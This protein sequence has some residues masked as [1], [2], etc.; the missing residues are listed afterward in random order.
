MVDS[1]QRLPIV[2]MPLAVGTPPDNKNIVGRE[3]TVAE[4]CDLLITGTSVALTGDRRYGK[5]SVKNLIV[6]ELPTRGARIVAISAQRQSLTDV[7]SALITQI[8]GSLDGGALGDFDKWSVQVKLGPATLTR[9]SAAARERAEATLEGAI[10]TVASLTRDRLV[11]AIDEV[12]EL[13]IANREDGA[14]LVRMLRRIRQEHPTRVSMLLLGSM[15][16]HH[17]DRAAPGAFNDVTSIAVGPISERDGVYLARCLM[18]GAAV[19]C[20]DGEVPVAQATY[21]AA[22]GIPYYVH[23]LVRMASRRDGRR[24]HSHDVASEVAAA[25]SDEQDPW[26]MR[27]YTDRVPGYYG[28]QADLAYAALDAYAVSPA[29]MDVDALVADLGHT[30]VEVERATMVTLLRDLTLDHYLRAGG[31]DPHRVRH[32]WSSALVREAWRLRRQV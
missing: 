22:E 19:T 4:V 21:A 16:L 2:P 30:G 6:E 14:A 13:F 9:E 20:Q 27:H 17:V 26:N 8:R 24:I 18:L 23:H 10:R 15:G 7:V 3:A 1:A 32:E 29:P 28:P 12:P 25:L 31:G 5:S 11:L